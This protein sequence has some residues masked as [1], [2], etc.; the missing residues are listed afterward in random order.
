[1]AHQV[2]RGTSVWSPKTIRRAGRLLRR[3]ARGQQQRQQLRHQKRLNA[4]ASLIRARGQAGFTLV[5]LG[6]VVTIVGILSVLAIVG[7]RR[8]I[9]SSH[10]AEATHM[11]NAIRTAQEAYRAETGG[12][13]PVSGS[14]SAGIAVTNASGNGC[15]NNSLMYPNSAVGAMKYAWGG[16]GG[17]AGSVTWDALPVHVD[18]PVM[19][20]Y[21]T[22]AGPAGSQPSAITLIKA[23][24]TTYSVSFPATPVTDW[25]LVGACGDP[26]GDGVYSAYLS[27]SFSNEIFVSNDGN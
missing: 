7:Y 25:F 23:G 2:L 8:L 27:S 1:M 19:Y 16:P 12:Y 9:T 14:T 13:A 11:V 3:L 20:G 17:S 6:A 26:D 4:P 24:A 21:T 22:V 18:G 15:A 10:S 5:E